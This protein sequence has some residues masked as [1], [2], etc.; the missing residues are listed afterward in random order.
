MFRA[1][2][3]SCI[4]ARRMPLRHLTAG[5][6]SVPS[7]MAMPSHIHDAVRQWYNVL[8]Q[9][10]E[11][12]CKEL[13]G[14]V[15]MGH[16]RKR[17]SRKEKKM[18]GKEQARQ[19]ERRFLVQNWVW[20]EYVD[21]QEAF[22]ATMQIDK[23]ELNWDWENDHGAEEVWILSDAISEALRDLD[24]WPFASCDAD[25]ADE[26]NE[27]TVHNLVQRIANDMPSPTFFDRVLRPRFM[28]WLREQDPGQDA[29][30]KR[31]LDVRLQQC[32]YHADSLSPS[33][34]F[35]DD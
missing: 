35:E 30:L 8:C 26:V 28:N 31:Y 23:G 10:H 16:A 3:P 20:E 15:V 33:C 12:K 22:K 13:Y 18:Y 24:H 7:D 27:P 21:Q 6:A 17:P 5:H 29:L 34:F 19:N 32:P 11:K 1:L 2:G 25:I 9:R 14:N 4:L